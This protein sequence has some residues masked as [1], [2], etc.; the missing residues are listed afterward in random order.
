MRKIGLC[1]RDRSHASDCMV[2]PQKSEPHS[3]RR[4]VKPL[5]TIRCA[6]RAGSLTHKSVARSMARTTRLVAMGFFRTNSRF[7]ANM[8]QKY[9]DHGRSRALLTMTRPMFCARKRCG[10]GGN[11][12]KASILPS[13]NKSIGLTFALVTHSISLAG[14]SPTSV[15]IALRKTCWADLKRLNADGSTLQIGDAAYAL[16]G[17]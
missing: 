7:P 10:S 5:S 12:R 8:Q 14:S 2:R 1:L 16:L 3:R 13:A 4:G 11:P 15:A 9:C 6:T 17:E